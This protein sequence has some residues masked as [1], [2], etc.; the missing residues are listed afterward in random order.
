MD[1]RLNLVVS[2]AEKGLA[3]LQGGLKNLV[4]LGKSGG[5]ALRDMARETRG[6]ERELAGV[7]RELAGASG[8]VSSLI[9][10]ERELERQLQRTNDQLRRQRALNRV[11]AQAAAMRA[12]GQAL[13]TRGRDNVLGG[14]TM[15]APLLL[16]TKK[17]AEFS[18][19]MV[20]IQQKAELTNA[21]T[22]RLAGSIQRIAEDSA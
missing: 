17:G 11:D 6:L 8:N 4:G 19:G 20:D 13:V 22:A 7:R 1:N 5:Q 10:R 14:A 15:L 3:Q 18:S 21:A 9:E 12:R 16:A 2:F